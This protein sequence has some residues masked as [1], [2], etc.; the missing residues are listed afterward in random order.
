MPNDQVQ[1]TPLNARP[2]PTPP[3]A[4]RVA[5]IAL[6][7]TIASSMRAQALRAAGRDIQSMA[8][9]ELDFDT[10]PEIIEAAHE[11]ALAGQTRYTAPDGTPALKAAVVE[12]LQRDQGLTVR[13]DNVHVASGAKQV[14]HNALAAT[15]EPGDEVVVLAPYWPSYADLVAYFD[16]RL[17]VVETQLRDGFTPDLARLREAFTPRTRWLILN[18]PGNPSG[19]I[20]PPAVLAA[21][22]ELLAEWP[23]CWVM[24]DEIY[25]QLWY[26]QRPLSFALAAP[27]VADRTLTL[28]GVSKAYA[29]TGWRIGYGA[30]P[31][32]LIEAMAKVQSQCAGNPA[33]VAQAAAVAALKGDV[34]RLET[35]RTALRDRRDFALQLLSACPD[36]ELP[37]PDGAF[38][39]FAGV[40]NVL[41][42]RTLQGVAIN[43][44]QALADWLLD[45]AGV[46]V[47]AGS[48]FG[49][50]GHLRF[51][52]ALDL[53]SLETACRAVVTALNTLAP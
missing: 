20:L 33:S 38:Y 16:G 39:I 25:D 23:Q 11:A 32:S 18:S 35:W 19:A 29:M 14:I 40:A 49:A 30:G 13:A 43:D 47:V 3:L 15:L 36:L 52:F 17:T 27:T 12:V 24:S 51:S 41:G 42:R 31:T 50:T 2:A 44:D 48:A 37:I 1:A 34:S 46:A 26:D 7:T 22:G 10:P 4:D 9:G 28:N 8:V 53:A 6:S 21:I 5:R 45:Q